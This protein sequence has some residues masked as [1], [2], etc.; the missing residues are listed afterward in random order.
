MLPEDVRPYKVPFVGDANV[1]K[2]SLLSRYTNDIFPQS[3]TATVGM[4]NVLTR[5][6]YAE[7]DF[8]VNIWDTAGQERF[9]SLVPL[10]A[11]DSDL[12]VLVYSVSSMESFKGLDDW[13]DQIRGEMRLMCPVIVVGN[14]TDLEFQIDKREALRW[15]KEHQCQTL[16]TSA[17]SADN[18]TELFQMIAEGLCHLGN[19]ITPKFS[20]DAGAAS[21]EDC[22]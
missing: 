3:P 13:F 15:G 8:A 6:R 11:R 14:K 5:L 16:F 18:V 22:C 4:T 20:W 21:Q 17:K 7:Q 10:Y 2:T 12:I 9:R 1:G 19:K